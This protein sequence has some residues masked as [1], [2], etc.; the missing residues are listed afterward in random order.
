M[1]AAPSMRRALVLASTV[2]LL[3]SIA[4]CNKKEAPADAP[5]ATMTE[6]VRVDDLRLGNAVGAD[7]WVTTEAD[8]FKPT[9]TIYLSVRTTGSAPSATL[10]AKWTFQDGQVV[11]DDSQTIAPNGTTN[12]AFYVSRPSGWPVGNYTVSVML[13]GQ[14]AG[15][16]DFEVKK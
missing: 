5:A 2:L 7:K 16:K 9:E 6:E 12:T 10:Q 15:S 8:D 13:N 14:S 4:A 11:K 1:N 3:G